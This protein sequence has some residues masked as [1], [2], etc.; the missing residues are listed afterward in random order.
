[1][2]VCVYIYMHTYTYI[3]MILLE[4]EH[5]RTFYLRM[6]KFFILIGVVVN[7]MYTLIKIHQIMHFVRSM[8]FVN[9][10]FT[11]EK[12]FKKIFKNKKEIKRK[13]KKKFF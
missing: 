13:R 10:T 1:M 4:M 6:E 2:Y 7:H 5:L 3:F 12:I 8:H 11:L 9:G